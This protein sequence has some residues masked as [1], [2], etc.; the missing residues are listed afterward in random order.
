MYMNLYGEY[1]EHDERDLIWENVNL[2]H[3]RH[4]ERDL[5]LWI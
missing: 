1:E 4:D 5:V 2:E 3:E